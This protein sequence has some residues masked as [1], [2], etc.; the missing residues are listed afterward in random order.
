VL[1][2]N[3]AYSGAWQNYGW[4]KLYLMGKPDEAERILLDGLEVVDCREDFGGERKLTWNLLH[5]YLGEG[6]FDEAETLL[7][8]M[9]E[10]WIGDPVG[11]HYFWTI[12][13]RLEETN[14]AESL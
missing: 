9:A 8:C 14:E 4:Y 10:K 11:N 3:P 1:E 7:Q 13:Q 6:R 5:L 12:V 2:R